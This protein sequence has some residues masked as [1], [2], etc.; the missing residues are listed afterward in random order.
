MILEVSFSRTNKNPQIYTDCSTLKS[1][2]LRV[3]KLLFV[4]KLHHMEK[5]PI[6]GRKMTDF[7]PILGPSVGPEVVK[8]IYIMR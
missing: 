2:K 5:W 6:F 3:V 7:G 4:V 8:M 1:L